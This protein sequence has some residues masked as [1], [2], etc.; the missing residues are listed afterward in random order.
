MKEKSA[1]WYLVPLL[2]GILGGIIAYGA[3]DNDNHNMAL[4]C[5]YIGIISTMLI[6]F[7]YA[8]GPVRY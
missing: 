3:L 2:F 8:V 1:W 7:I 6:F 4:E 5:L